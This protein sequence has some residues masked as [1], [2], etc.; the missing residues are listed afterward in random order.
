M[1]SGTGLAPAPISS[2]RLRSAFAETNITVRM[3][4]SGQPHQ[5]H[6]IGL[7][8]QRAGDGSE[9]RGG[10]VRGPWVDDKLLR[11]VRTG[12]GD[13]KLHGRGLRGAFVGQHEVDL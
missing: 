9:T 4:L 5:P 10:D 13:L 6:R 8:A 3:L 12:A 7:E 2:F 11:L 1:N